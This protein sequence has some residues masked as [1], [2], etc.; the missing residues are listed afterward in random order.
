M[1]MVTRM[2]LTRS[3]RS[4]IAPANGTRKTDGNACASTMLPSHAPEWVRSHVSQPMPMRIIH[5]PLSEHHDA[6]E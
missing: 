3:I 4:A 6:I 5:M 1:L 2:I